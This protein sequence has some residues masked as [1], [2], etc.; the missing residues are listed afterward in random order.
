MSLEKA[1]QMQMK[2]YGFYASFEKKSI[3]LYLQV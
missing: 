3:K 1:K 2:L